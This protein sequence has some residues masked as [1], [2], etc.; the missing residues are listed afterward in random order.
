MPPGRRLDTGHFQS[1][2]HWSEAA[3]ALSARRAAPTLPCQLPCVG[4]SIVII[5][6][7]IIN[8]TFSVV[9]VK[10]R[11]IPQNGCSYHHIRQ[12]HHHHHH[13]FI[14]MIIAQS[15]ANAKDICLKVIPVQF[16]SP[17]L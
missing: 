11:I 10:I 9:F 6:I 8:I 1:E 17:L 4:S 15:V 14:N 3:P 5:I 16:I 13:S 7:I 2:G 12:F